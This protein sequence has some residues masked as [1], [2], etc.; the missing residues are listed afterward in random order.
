[1][2]ALCR[3]SGSK[4][5]LEKTLRPFV[6]TLSFSNDASK[7]LG[8]EETSLRSLLLFS[9]QVGSYSCDPMDCSTPGLPVPH[10][11]SEFAQVHVH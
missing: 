4:K 7:A 5:K 11:L 9:C 6:Q 10:H 3:S 2:E 8:S 1:M